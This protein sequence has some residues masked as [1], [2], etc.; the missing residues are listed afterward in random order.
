MKWFTHQSIAVGAAL[1]LNLSPAGLA[2][3]VLGSV[4]PDMVDQR[5]ARLTPNPQKTFN[6]IHRGASHWFGWYVALLLVGFACQ[7]FWPQLLQ[8]PRDLITTL[9][10]PRGTAAFASTQ[11]AAL[12]A[13]VGFGA[14][15]HVLLDMLTPS[16]VP[17]HPFSRQNK[18]SLKVC[19]TGSLGE[20]LFLAAG[21]AVIAVFGH[22][23]LPEIAK[24]VEKFLR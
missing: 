10:L 6:R 13:G 19:S 23:R 14:L 9:H 4:L 2:G 17:L 11:A 16:G 20:Y 18:L 1:V 3:V 21:L 7:T 5:L 12:L 22:E 8:L 15:M 24:A